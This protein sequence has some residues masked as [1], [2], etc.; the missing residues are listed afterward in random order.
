MKVIENE[1]DQ[2]EI[3]AIFA[4]LNK[5]W[6]DHNGQAFGQCFTEDADYV[7]CNGQHSRGRQAIADVR[8]ELFAGN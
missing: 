2:R 7:T 6:N 3:T 1:Q 5:A 8:Q 4:A